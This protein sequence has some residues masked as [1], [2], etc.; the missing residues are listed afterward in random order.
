MAFL[1]AII[2]GIIV[3]VPVLALAKY[4]SRERALDLM[5]VQLAA[6][7]AV[8]AGSS[9]AGGGIPVFVAEMIGVT[10]F[11]VVALFGRWGSPAILAAGYFAHG[12]WDAIHELGVISTFLPDWYAPFCLGYDGIVGAF[13]A[14]VFVRRGA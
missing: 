10:A 5:A 12:A 7:A 1:V 4:I 8:Y 14:L 11:V 3:A 13:V 2:V 9:L 6:I